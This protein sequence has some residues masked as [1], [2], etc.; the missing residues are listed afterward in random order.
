MITKATYLTNLKKE[1]ISNTFHKLVAM[2]LTQLSSPPLH[3]RSSTCLI[4]TWELTRNSIVLWRS[5]WGCMRFLSFLS[6]I[7]SCFSSVSWCR[8]RRWSSISRL[9]QILLL[10]NHFISF[11]FI[12]WGVLPAWPIYRNLVIFFCWFLDFFLKKIIKFS[13]QK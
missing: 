5:I 8:H 2:R 7:F 13:T 1:T 10:I 11:H 12:F 4:R 9:S 3:G 6:F